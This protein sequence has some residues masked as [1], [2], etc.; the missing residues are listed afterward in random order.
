M[1]RSNNRL[2]S[3][4][5]FLTVSRRLLRFLEVLAMASKKLRA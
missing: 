1:N 5:R 2:R 4:I 3:R